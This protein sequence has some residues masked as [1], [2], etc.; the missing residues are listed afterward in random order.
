MGKGKRRRVVGLD[1]GAVALIERWL[2]VRA[3]LGADR[4]WRPSTRRLICTLEGGPVRPVYYRQVLPRLA[5]RA[6]I[7]KRVHPHALRHTHAY[8]LANEGLPPHL[9]Q[10]QL[11][12]TSLATTDR[13]LRHIAPM[14]L[15]R[16]ITAREWSA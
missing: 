12:H 1:A 16:A 2:D 11:G 14:E 13:Y 9:I 6:G 8:E 7:E 5:A 4:G 10:A 3:K 15:V